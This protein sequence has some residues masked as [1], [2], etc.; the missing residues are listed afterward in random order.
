MDKNIQEESPRNH[1]SL[2]FSNYKQTVYVV[3]TFDFGEMLA[4][5]IF[6][7]SNQFPLVE[8]KHIAPG[9]SWKPPPGGRNTSHSTSSEVRQVGSVGLC[10]NPH[11]EDAVSEN[12]WVVEEFKMYHQYV[13]FFY[14]I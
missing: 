1:L 9:K 10:K 14:A 7:S 4:L 6:L 12:S 3:L 8:V 5:A 2:I 13:P 11:E